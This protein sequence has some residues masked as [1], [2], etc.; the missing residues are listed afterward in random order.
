MV[1]E[2][3]WLDKKQRRHSPP[4]LLVNKLVV[5][6]MA[7]IAY[8]YGAL[9]PLDW[10]DDC[11]VQMKLQ[12]DLWNALVTIYHE[13]GDTIRSLTPTTKELTEAAELLNDIK[14]EV[15]ELEVAMKADKIAR[16]FEK[17]SVTAG[18][19][20]AD[21]LRLSA[22]RAN[23]KEAAQTRVALAKKARAEFAAD[24]V[25]ATYDRQQVQIKEARQTAAAKG[26]WWGNYNA[27]MT[28]FDGA[29]S[30]IAKSGGELKKKYFHGEGR[31]TAQLQ[32][33][34]SAEEMF[35]PHGGR[36]EARLIEGPPPGWT[37]IHAPGSKKTPPTP[38]AKREQKRRMATLVLTVY[39]RRGVD[40]KLMRRVLN[41]P[42]IYNR[43]LPPD[44]RVQQ[45]AMT[46]RRSD[47]APAIGWR[48]EVVFTLR[49]PDPVSSRLDRKAAVHVGWRAVDDGVRVATVADTQGVSYFVLPQRLASR[50]E[51]AS[52][53]VSAADKDAE[54]MRATV[55]D[56]LMPLPPATIQADL[57]AVR[58][59]RSGA[60]VA[61]SLRW[62][63]RNWKQ[64][65]PEYLANTLA[66]L[67][68]WARNDLRY[69][70]MARNI[71]A[72]AVRHRQDLVRV[73]VAELARQYDEVIIQN[74]D[75]SRLKRRDLTDA[76]V[77]SGRRNV[78]RMAPGE[79]R[80]ALTMSLKSRGVAVR[81][82]DQKASWVC[83]SCGVEHAPADPLALRVR[84]PGCGIYWD[85]DDN[86]A[87]NA[88]A[89]LVSAGYPQSVT[90]PIA[91]EGGRF[92]KR[93]ALYASKMVDASA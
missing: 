63:A 89:A 80:A 19:A 3:S 20:G 12:T 8:K 36:N 84:C 18:K 83:H 93:K 22:L 52:T 27:I 51:T 70:W 92:A 21:K 41:I 44:A 50:F 77:P 9:R 16:Y 67:D 87:K 47:Q 5:I 73:W 68:D 81:S 10:G 32:G 60:G 40:S 30:R 43:P 17:G 58:Q 64:L 55:L 82:H 23:L 26:L 15:A 88:L 85:I 7:M 59:A 62:M 66:I 39:T 86:A 29:R 53:M 48:Y 54:T 6:A 76:S 1:G 79:L 61:R 74:Y 31:L 72:K 90:E 11:L 2:Y 69:R 13:T 24:Q 56:W 33:G 45:V 91:A 34:A 65:T 25:A 42:F 49:V 75:I 4:L 46:R 57:E 28:S 78:Q 38:G 14:E 35:A 71:Q 37:D